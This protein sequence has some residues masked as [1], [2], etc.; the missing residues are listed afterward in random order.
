MLPLETVPNFSEGRDPAT[1]DALGQAL[2]SGGARVLDVHRD[3][4]HNR[5][6]F[7]AVGAAGELEQGLAAAAAVAVERIDLRSHEGVHPC[8]GSLDI[9]PIVPLDERRRPEAEA[10][11]ARLAQRFAELGL[12]SLA[13][14]ESSPQRLRPHDLRRGGQA[15]LAERLARGEPAPLAGPGAPHPRAGAVMLGVRRPLLAYNVNLESDRLDVARAIAASVRERDGGLPGVRALGLP[16]RSLGLVQVSMNIERPDVV[17][18]QRVVEAIRQEA[19]TYGVALRGGELVGL[20][21]AAAAA[22]VAR[23]YLQLPELT[24]DRLIEVAVLRAGMGGT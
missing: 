7:T 5:A 2:E 16:L 12:P 23:H 11:V 24:A 6:V 18:L 14:A 17:P 4:D 1:L 19:H 10:L 21:P 3:G 20:M 8:I 13:Y 9:V 22:G 15:G